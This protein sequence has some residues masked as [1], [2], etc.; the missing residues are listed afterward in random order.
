MAQGELLDIIKANPG[1]EQAELPRLS[2][3]NR[4]T[5]IHQVKALVRWDKIYR[6]RSKATYKLYPRGG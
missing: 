3:L 2:G 6:E 1:I 5:V 4:G